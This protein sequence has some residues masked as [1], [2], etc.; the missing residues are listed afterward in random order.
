MNPG[1]SDAPR[2]ATAPADRRGERDLERQLV[3]IT[4]GLPARPA[5]KVYQLWLIGPVKIVSAGLLPRPGAG[6]PR[7]CWRPGSSGATSSA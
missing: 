1:D 5:A 4:D 7:R 3:V 6:G 2:F